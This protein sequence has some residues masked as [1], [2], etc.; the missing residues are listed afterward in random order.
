MRTGGGKAEPPRAEVPEDRGDKQ[1]EDH[2][3][4]GARTYLQDQFDGQEGDDGECYCSRGE[5]HSGEVADA[6]PHDGDIR[7]ERVG[8][9]DGGDGVGRVV[10]SVDEFKAE[11]NQQRQ[12]EQAVGCVAGD[13]RSVEIV[14]YVEDDVDDAGCERH[15]KR[16]DALLARRALQLAVE[17]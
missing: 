10:K 13:G 3:E 7:L 15:Q 14:G 1:R 6:R 12:R 16:Q 5:K 9:D 2:G 17:E 4:A 8:V 11:R